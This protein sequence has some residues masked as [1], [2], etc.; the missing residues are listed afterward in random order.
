MA[1]GAKD[2]AVG[3]PTGL[4]AG[5]GFANPP[6]KGG[7]ERVEGAAAV[8]WSSKREA[9]LLVDTGGVALAS[10]MSL[11]CLGGVLILNGSGFCVS[12]CFCADFVAAKF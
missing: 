4:L 8:A 6:A 1:G 5:A 2:F 12:V 9:E 7:G 3:W 10:R 11:P